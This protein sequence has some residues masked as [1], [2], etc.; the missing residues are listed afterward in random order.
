MS[1]K[2]NIASRAH[3][4]TA[5]PTYQKQRH[6]RRINV[7]SPPSCLRL[8][9]LILALSALVLVTASLSS[10][11][12]TREPS[13]SYKRGKVTLGTIKHGTLPEERVLE[14]EDKELLIESMLVIVS[15]VELHSCEEREREQAR[16][17]LIPDAHAHVP[18]SA[19]RLGTPFAE[20]LLG[21]T[22]RAS[23]VSEIAPPLGSYCS[24]WV[25]IAPADDDILNPTSLGTRELVGK[26][27]II[28]GKQ[29][30]K[31]DEAWQDFTR[32][33]SIK[34]AFEVPITPIALSPKKDSAFV[35]IDKTLDAQ[36]W[37]ELDPSKLV[38]ES[39][40]EYVLSRYLERLER[41]TPK[42]KQTGSA[43]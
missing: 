40:A 1:E 36:W 25:I 4:A 29:R 13:S 23:I 5:S 17:S 39:G 24:L 27:F 33:S 20:D 28:K 35:L 42:K 26:S 2:F 15:D 19:T 34:R 32:T 12:P 7:S 9:R 11:A 3:D 30:V 21:A 8:E 16:F 43:D 31:G 22:G 10:C 14:F 6:R 38:Q 18:D 37:E 41:Y